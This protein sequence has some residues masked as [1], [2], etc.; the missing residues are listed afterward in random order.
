[1]CQVRKRAA[2]FQAHKVMMSKISRSRSHF[3]WG[4]EGLKSQTMGQ[5]GHQ[6]ESGVSSSDGQ[7][8]DR[9]KDK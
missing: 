8:S 3:N 4:L 7:V 9:I 6:R 1:M 2:I 5:R